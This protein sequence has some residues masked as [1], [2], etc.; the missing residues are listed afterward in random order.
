MR[1]KAVRY[2]V[3]TMFGTISIGTVM[4]AVL[5]TKD[6]DTH[7]ALIYHPVHNKYERG[8]F[9]FCKQDVDGCYISIDNESYINIEKDAKQ[10]EHILLGQKF[11]RYYYTKVQ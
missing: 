5:I 8:C 10:I 1:F 9:E 6:P 7:K 4:S 2:R 3:T 11:K